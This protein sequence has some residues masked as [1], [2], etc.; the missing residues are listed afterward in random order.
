MQMYRVTY[1]PK[2]RDPFSVEVLADGQTEAAV[3]SVALV[4]LPDV[5]YTVDVA[6][7]DDE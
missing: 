7:V 4:E 1:S 6:D 5:P 3:A 2:G